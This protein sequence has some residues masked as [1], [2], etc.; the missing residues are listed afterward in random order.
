[1]EFLEGETLADR[2]A[3]GPLP[4]EQTLRYATQIADALDKAHRQGIV[5]RDLKPANVMLTKAR[6]EAARLRS[7]QG[8]RRRLGP[9]R[10]R[11]LATVAA[12]R[13]S[14]AAARIAGTVQYMAPEQLEGRPA[15]ARSDIFALGAVIYEMATA[16]RAFR[17]RR[18]TRS[19]RRR[20]IALVRTCLAADPD[21]RWQS[22]HDVEL[23]LTSIAECAAR[24][25]APDAEPPAGADTLGGR[26]RQSP[27]GAAD[28]GELF[29]RAPRN[30]APASPRRPFRD[31]R[32]PKAVRSR[33]T[34][35]RWAS[36]CRR[37]AR[38]WPT[39]PPDAAGARRV[40][41]RALSSV[42]ARPVPG[43]EDA[44]TVI[45]SPD[46]RSI[47]FFAAD[48]L[49]RLIVPDGAPVTVSDV[50]MYGCPP[51]GAR[52]RFC[53]PPFRAGFFGSPPAAA[54]RCSNAPWTGRAARSTRIGRG[55]CPTASDSSI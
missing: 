18:C 29:G 30:P 3:H 25:S 34:S 41:L 10:R 35:K 17:A 20:S 15:D 33:T 45:W 4:L 43:T 9:T 5:H 16:T 21:E 1:M 47:A 32:R 26:E 52:A 49:K 50:P 55:S 42:D 13:R 51:P 8:C 40:W 38:S 36:R 12:P 37:T 27:R 53:L 23:Q 28:G 19:R 7:G 6:R 22:A 48:K 39:S 46:G 44:R 54:R 11:A 2:L 24:G 14:P 31:P